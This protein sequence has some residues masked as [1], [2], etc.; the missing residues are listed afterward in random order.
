VTRG[1]SSRTAWYAADQPLQDL[2]EFVAVPGFARASIALSPGLDL[3][4]KVL[5][6]GRHC[7]LLLSDT[8][9]AYISDS[10]L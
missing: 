5:V 8:L 6:D 4:E 3:I 9:R 1:G 7:L 2:A 10:S